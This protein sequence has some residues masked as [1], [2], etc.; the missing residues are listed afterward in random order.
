MPLRN[1][2]TDW[3]WLAK[4]LHWAVAAGIFW[5]IWLGLTQA[6]MPRGAEKQAVRATHASWAL[7][8]LALM[9]LRL[10]WRLANETPAHPAGTPG[11]QRV[12]ATTVH[13]AIYA[14]VFTQLV[15]GAMVFA[16]GGNALP[17]FDLFSIPLPVA[18]D[19]DAHEFW[20]EIHE[21]V[22]KPL[23]AIVVLHFL[24]ALYNH[25]MRRNDVLRRMTVG[26]RT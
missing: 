4:A 25:F 1:T 14:L 26:S 15:A 12:T 6:D 19:R 21:F 23:L 17:F 3:G 2:A 10:V 24:A 18:E 20:E 13:W 5:L 7:L 9:A 11:W 8:V 16:T 22:W